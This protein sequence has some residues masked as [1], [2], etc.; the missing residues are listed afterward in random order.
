MSTPEEELHEILDYHFAE[1]VQSLEEFMRKTEREIALDRRDFYTP[2]IRALEAAIRDLISEF[3]Q[4]EADTSDQTIVLIK[5]EA[6]IGRLVKLSARLHQKVRNGNSRS[7]AF[8]LWTEIG[9]QKTVLLRTYRRIFVANAVR[10]ALF[11]RWV[12]KMH[13]QREHR[14]SHE[15][16]TKFEREARA[17]TAENGR[18]VEGLER[19]LESAR[20][21]LEE[22]HQ[23]LLEMQQRL[24]KAFMRGVVNLNLEAMDVFNGGQVMDLIKEVE[25]NEAEHYDDEAVLHESDDDFFVEEAPSISVIRHR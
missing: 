8:N 22:K 5:K 19:E 16:R 14:L 12:R 4:M 10:R 7:R 2:K 15:I 11:R 25:G 23:K 18:I 24:R 21:E 13:Q 3:N 20:E 1:L 6:I 17:R 9:T